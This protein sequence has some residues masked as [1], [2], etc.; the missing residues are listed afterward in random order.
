VAWVSAFLSEHHSHGRH[1]DV[2]KVD[3]R[4]DR[5]LTALFL[6]LLIASAKNT[7][8]QKTN[9]SGTTRT[10]L[11]LDDLLVQLV[12]KRLRCASFCGRAVSAVGRSHLARAVKAAGVPPKK[13]PLFSS[14]VSLGVRHELEATVPEGHCRQRSLQSPLAPLRGFHTKP[15]GSGRHCFTQAAVRSRRRSWHHGFLGLAAIFL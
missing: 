3:G 8:D 9:Q 2:V 13:S 4:P 5:H 15:R 10:V 7:F 6:G 14:P 12:L 1:Q 11:I